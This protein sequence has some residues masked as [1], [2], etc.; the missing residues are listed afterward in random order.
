MLKF[1]TAEGRAAG[2]PPNYL[3]HK[4]QRPFWIVL[5]IFAAG[6]WLA[7]GGNP[8]K[9]AQLFG[10]GKTTTTA[11]DHDAVGPADN[12]VAQVEKPADEPGVVQARGD[13]KAVDDKNTLF[14]GL[15]PDLFAKLEDD[16]VYRT[17]EEESLYR[18]LRALDEA[19]E[20]D[21]RL[22]SL[23]PVTFRQL[24]E[25]SN[26]YRGE[27]VTLS[28][29]AV[30]I[31][32]QK[33]N[34]NPHG[35]EKY[36]EVW[37]KPA[38]GRV[39]LVFLCLDMPPD[40][41]LGQ[42]PQQVEASGY[43]YKRLGYPSEERD[44]EGRNV[45]RSSPLVLAKTL[46]WTPAAGP[47]QMAEDAAAQV[48]GLPPGLPAKWVLPLLGIGIAL[49]IFLSVYAY[50][51]TKTSV[52]DRGPIVGRARRAAEAAEKPQNLNELKIEP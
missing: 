42:G 20:R 6:L 24:S 41:P 9:W 2:R 23:G 47:Q 15:S 11:T 36:Y 13:T 52:L 49:M 39:P 32:P 30:R 17:A 4:F 46:H 35:I 10:I 51:L 26:R 8:E 22:A 28:G 3:G 14:G 38:G 33:A 1:R 34:V 12:A 50:R 40:Y 45:F 29:E 31:V 18:A 7:R 43:F 5:L 16:A 27:I 44:A 19:D 48:P 37:L 21:V 25:Q